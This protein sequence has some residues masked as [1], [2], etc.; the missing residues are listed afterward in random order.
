MKK[1]NPR[2]STTATAC[3][4]LAG[5]AIATCN[6]RARADDV[7][8]VPVANGWVGSGQAT[9]VVSGKTFDIN[10]TS[11]NVSLNWQSFNIGSENTVNFH[12]PSAT[13]VALNRIFSND[14]AAIRGALNA[15][16]E[17]YL[18]S[19]NGIVFGST[20]QVNV[21]G[22]VA[23]TLN[24]TPLAESA[25]LT[26]PAE[27]G[28]AAFTAAR[29]AQ[30]NLLSDDI[31][32]QNGAR[33]TTPEGGRVFAFAPNVTNEGAIKTPGGQTALAAGTSIFLSAND[34]SVRGLVVEVGGGGTVTNGAASSPAGTIPAGTIQADRGNVSLV[35]LAVNQNGRISAGTAV[36]S[37]GSIR[38]MARES[39]QVVG[40]TAPVR[41]G[42][43]TFGA[44]SVTEANPDLADK[45]T[46]LD[47]N[48]QPRGRIEGAG[49]QVHLRSGARLSAHSGEVILDASP[50][51]GKVAGNETSDSRIYLESGSRIDVSG[52]FVDLPADRNAL[53]VRLQGAELRDSPVQRDSPLRGQQVTVDV[54]RRGVTA[55]G[56]AWI[57]TPLADLTEA[58]QG[59]RRTVGERSTTGGTVQLN[60]EGDVI[61]AQGS[62]IDVSGGGVRYA[63]GAVQTTMLVR[64]GVLV[65]IGSADPN[66]VYDGVFGAGQ[67]VHNRW[68]IVEEFRSERIGSATS[69]GG[70]G[71]FV[72]GRDAGLV[73]VAAQQ[74]VI[75]GALLG[76]AQRGEFQRQ[77]PTLTFTGSQRPTDQAPRG[78]RLVIGFADKVGEEFPDF[79]PDTASFTLQPILPNIP[80][81]DPLTQPLPELAADVSIPVAIFGEG[82]FTGLDIYA[83]GDVTVPGGVNLD[84]GPGGDLKVVSGGIDFDGRVTAHAGSV[85]LTT[86]R[87]ADRVNSGGRIDFSGVI[88]V[89]GLWTND[90]R[91]LGSPEMPFDRLAITGG[92]VRIEASQES[93]ETGG[94]FMTAG[95]RID[96][97][98]G[99]WVNSAGRV[100]GGNGGGV[101][102]ITR[103]GV[104]AA[105]VALDL[106]GAITADSLVNNGT[107]A[108]TASDVCIAATLCAGF[109]AASTAW[110][111]PEFLERG[112]FRSYSFTADGGGFTLADGTSFTLRQR[113]RVLD[114]NYQDF[115]D[116]A[117]LSS[118]STTGTLTDQQRKPVDFSAAV[119]VRFTGADSFFDEDLRAAGQLYFGTGASITTDPGARVSL[120]SDTRL[121]MDGTITA[122]A[123]TITLGINSAISGNRFGEFMPSQTLWLGS[124]ASLQARGTSFVQVDDLGRR[125]GT[126]SGG[127]SVRID[128]ASGYVIVDNGARIDVSGT[129]EQLDISFLGVATP[130]RRTVAS[131]GG[132]I[133]LE[134][135]EGILIGGSF[136]AAAGGAGA[137]DGSLT[138]EL[139][140]S[141]RNDNTT[142]PN[143]TAEDLGLSEAPRRIIVSNES[144]QDA[145][146][147]L[148]PGEPIDPRY[149][150]VAHVDPDL[151]NSGGFGDVTLRAGTLQRGDSIA[152]RV[153]FEGDVSLSASR[154]LTLD[155]AGIESNGGSATLNAAYVAIGNHDV[156]NSAAATALPEFT[157]VS[158]T[159]AV[160]ADFIDLV[161]STRLVGL[162]STE[163]S[164]T[165]DIRLRGSQVQ[166]QTHINGRLES[167]GDIH[168]TAR[169][170]YAPTLNEFTVGVRDN[171]EGRIVIDAVGTPA[172]VLSAGSRL[173]FEA[174]DILQRGVIKAPLG[175]IV[176]EAD[177]D[178]TLA[179]GSLTSTSLENLVVPFGRVEVGTDWVYA[180]DANQAGALRLVFN[181]QANRPADALPRQNVNLKAPNVQLAEGAVLDQR[182]GGDLLAYEFQAGLGG[183][184]DVLNPAVAPNNYAIVPLLGDSYAP[185]DPQESL[186]FGLKPGESI[187]LLS[188]LPGLPAGRYALLPA[189]Y[190][191]LPGAYLVTATSNYRDLAPGAVVPYSQGGS[192]LAGRRVFADGSQGD[193]RTSGFVI[194]TSNDIQKLAQYDTY[195]ASNFATGFDGQ[196][197]PQ[198]GGSTRIEAAMSLELGGTIRASGAA[199][200]RGASVE[201]T[202]DRLAVVDNTELHTADAGSLILDAGGLNRLGAQSLILGATREFGDDGAHLDVSSQ[203]VEIDSGVEL[204]APELILAATDTVR[205][206]AG[207]TLSGRGST[208]AAVTTYST[209]GDGA[210][211][212][213][214]SNRQ[215][216][217]ARTGAT[218]AGGVLDV[219]AGATLAATGSTLLSGSANV[220]FAGELDMDGGS[221]N[222]DASSINLGTPQTAASGFTLT[223]EGL[224]A[225]DVDELR[226]SGR[227]GIDIFEPLSVNLQRVLLSAPSINGHLVGN[228]TVTFNVDSLEIANPAR[229]AAVPGTGVSA[230]SLAVNA[231][232]IGIGVGEVAI[233]GF[234]SVALTA[235]NDITALG[236]QSA[237]GKVFESGR[238]AVDGDLTMTARVITGESK[239]DIAIAASGDVRIAAGGSAPATMPSALGA[240]LAISGAS[241]GDAGRIVLRSGS[242]T[243]H[244]TGA[245]GSV[246]VEDGATIDVSGSAQRFANRDAYVR[247][248]DV[249]LAADDGNVELQ[250]GSRV[251]L[252]G[253][254]GGGD[255]G[256]LEVSAPGGTFVAAGTVRAVAAVEYDG[257]ASVIDVN[258]LADFGALNRQLAAGGF[259]AER[260]LRVRSGDIDVAAGETV[261]ADA[262]RLTADAGAIRVAGR[263]DA[264]AEKAGTILLSA[265]GD[266]D[267]ISGAALVARSTGAGEAGG[268]VSLA[269]TD[270]GVRVASGS[271]IDVSAGPGGT[272][273]GGRVDVRVTR[274]AALTLLDGDAGN[275]RLALAGAITGARRVDLEAYQSY[276][277]SDGVLDAA[278]VST[279][280]NVRY[281]EAAAFIAD[282]GAA[283]RTALGANAAPESFH[284]LAG[285]E[286]ATD[287]SNPDLRL[288]SDWDLSQWR[289]GGEAG[290]LT[291]RAARNLAFD[292]SLSDGFD[293]VADLT[294][295][296][297]SQLRTDDS[298]SYRLV[299]GADLTSA[300][301]L[302]TNDARSGSITIA[303]GVAGSATARA[304]QI[305]IR[306]GTGS[307][308]LAS[309]GDVT[310]GNRASVIYT[311]GRDTGI[312]FRLGSA[313]GTL[314]NRPYPLMGGD[315]SMR[316]GGSVH[317]VAEELR[318]DLSQYGNQL[319]NNWLFRQGASDELALG[320]A[321]RATGWT[322]AFE[323][324]EQGIAAL[325]GGNVSVV[326]GGDLDNVSISIPSIGVQV[327]GTNVAASRVDVM[328]GGDLTVRAGGD[329]AGGVY[330]TGKGDA[331]I[332]TDGS[333][334]AGRTISE[335]TTTPLRTMLALG[336]GTISL[337]ARGAL[338]LDGVVNPT[339]LPQASQQRPTQASPKS[340]FSTY[341]ADSA[342]RLASL[343]GDV[344]LFN[345]ATEISVGQVFGLTF[346]DDNSGQETLGL[347]IYAPTL[348]AASFS[349]D[350]N[351]DGGFTLF[352]SASGDLRLFADGNLNIRSS[353]KLADDNPSLLPSVATPSAQ[354]VKFDVLNPGS[355]FFDPRAVHPTEPQ[356]P[357]SLVARDGDITM[358]RP[359][360][361]VLSKPAEFTAGRDIV[362]LNALVQNVN[363]RDVT[364]ISAG[365]DI[366]YPS[367]RQP[368]GAI[369]QNDAGIDVAGP[370]RVLVTAGRDIDLGASRGIST[371]GDTTNASLADQ[372]AD[373]TLMAGIGANG[374]ALEAFATKYGVAADLQSV[375]DK[376]YAI[377]RESGRTNAPLPNEKRS[378]A[379][380][381]EA[382]NTLFP[383]K[384]YEG[385]IDMFFSRVYTLDGG[386]I[387]LLLPGGGVNVGL[388]AP[389]SAFG[390]SKE[391]SQLGLV[392]QSAGSVRAFLD[393]N[394]E[395][396]ESRVFAADGGDILVWSSNGDIDAG[397]GAKTSISAPP[398]VVSIDPVTG[399]VTVTFPP[400][401]TGSGIRTLTST[402]GRQFG[403]VDLITPRGVVDA[404]EAGIETLGN[405][406]IAAVQVLGTQNIKVGGVS[407]G[408]PVDTGGLSA[409]LAGV[410][411]V[412]SSAAS[413]TSDMAGAG[414]KTSK[415]PIADAAV[416]F[417]EMFVIGF[418]E[419]VCNPKDVECMKRQKPPD[420]Q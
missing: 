179:S 357:A 117:D 256:R 305:A 193:A 395:V 316:A 192:V 160:S 103:R 279:A 175:S 280:G 399:A 238:L 251:D 102:L 28:E 272:D 287:A 250:A 268:R 338:D 385:S 289:F 405:L 174:T 8:P 365:R 342:V 208:S 55:D 128:A 298:W 132:S 245:D 64:N 375:L 49:D 269:S 402:P 264:T 38:L 20:A 249:T 218:G 403:S 63:D 323:R 319:V 313:R 377:L 115:A 177:R 41:G 45:E 186:Q 180:L 42:T 6:N 144:L 120:T 296:A 281:D 390:I 44:N 73:G 57:G 207:A 378:Y 66:L 11:Q 170:V 14:P 295:F 259:D 148:V 341:G 290:V 384:S 288:T 111:T 339:L 10:Q 71:G 152:G 149:D 275:D 137:R 232:S 312:G 345:N 7:L 56:R 252:S 127:G 87:T 77:L 162:R 241:V 12:Q 349:G 105:P 97:D 302:A 90:V 88:D 24:L 368:E 43:L 32:I 48:A 335:T 194:R 47:A 419:G 306:T 214:A 352:P 215:G 204:A 60:A 166:G 326:A 176:L 188:S 391:A 4:V 371:L 225:L 172:P 235:T 108:I 67:T 397:R 40:S 412:S 265:G 167:T 353:F 362:N 203:Q 211:L 386:D 334:V 101:T 81:F 163:F 336:D 392:A 37:G 301:L 409:S 228:E 376:F 36:R 70:T 158:G 18:L 159:L 213:V 291:L 327:G 157:G 76:E 29:D 240:R 355:P 248:G 69:S 383:E 184:F 22:L 343:A 418:G 154:R 350:I 309:A 333:V 257:G 107:L 389:P 367:L 320:Q 200:G 321:R 408:V 92:N 26:R 198:D 416:S 381:F 224:A 331:D 262:V 113:N 173:T 182:G 30:G 340:F 293:G 351:V 50:T 123:G 5:L 141:E 263:I 285:I 16:G 150:A 146:D 27:S 19:Q 104:D 122:P 415:A 414:D 234:D 370:G 82:N 134:A 169:Q 109:D 233:D 406:T 332:R 35:G 2:G 125:S 15:N 185:I 126:V 348:E 78:G 216:A 239:A 124:N 139:N 243:L 417:L 411:A 83:N 181:E 420:A 325:G 258:T 161:G 277:E 145:I 308:D 220:G 85:S 356:S 217:F 202:G 410:S 59:V 310:L 165:G 292:R 195:R 147:D 140:A 100:T 3:T 197:L 153:R 183:S 315:I 84:L 31:F 75:D 242:L 34:A 274:N 388:A 382:I 393:D 129:S 226:L 86:R 404:S 244:A 135:A 361:A 142:D 300:D 116:R 311:A 317:G 229:H 261:R 346:L 94:L 380:A 273:N 155:A 400:A 407:T 210:L 98:G 25:G 283:L 364:V 373:V 237:S 254:T 171:D 307:I 21:R 227:D 206:E 136:T 112:G 138:I 205:V 68:G 106:D 344:T 17:V 143:I 72:E 322:V 231:R 253:A 276:V 196:P 62:T 187:E 387:D 222:V 270:G 278:G 58:A 271:N 13:S 401:L 223:S 121:F 413:A 267:V 74:I 1:K 260:E 54:R 236:A 99:A 178:L 246:V 53:T 114:S 329:I 9:G 52:E 23:S 230:G 324:F 394:F 51:G 221:L 33:I 65:D 255:A 294:E 396:N 156:R 119:R 328:A 337:E 39:V 299:A 247:A 314:E 398:P 366:T 372:G 79:G 358:V 359:A 347:S 80:A 212:R 118:F 61:A 318:G 91:P 266:V 219:Q 360:A 209:S 131:D 46:T 190:A 95:S 297:L 89:S 369:M 379:A 199:G 374:P 303:P 133:H 330:F 93:S 151:V 201:I 110:L 189:R 164:S 304:N 354:F 363:A 282:S 168:F 286:I 191:L 130:Q 284:L 96:A